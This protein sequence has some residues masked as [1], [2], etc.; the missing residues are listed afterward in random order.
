MPDQNG[1]AKYSRVSS[2]NTLRRYP[3]FETFRAEYN[4]V[5]PSRDDI[6]IIG[7]VEALAMAVQRHPMPDNTYRRPPMRDA[8]WVFTASDDAGTTETDSSDGVDIYTEQ[9]DSSDEDP[10]DPDSPG[11]NSESSSSSSSSSTSNSGGSSR[12]SGRDSDSSGDGSDRGG[13]VSMTGQGGKPEREKAFAYVNGLFGEE[14]EGHMGDSEGAGG[15]KLRG[16][17]RKRAREDGLTRVAKRVRRYQ[18]GSK[19]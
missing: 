9:S 12:F 17:G 15:Q 1:I 18:E 16:G 19:I 8:E 13:A 10:S 14:D 5:I 4:G 3:D 11:P 6:G 2:S 7:D